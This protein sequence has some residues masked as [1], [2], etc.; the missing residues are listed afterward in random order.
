MRLN[1]KGWS[2]SAGIAFLCV[3]ILFVII[4]AILTYRFGINKESP[5]PIYNE[6]MPDPKENLLDR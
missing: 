1:N 3:L 5:D 4:V 6:I 2:F